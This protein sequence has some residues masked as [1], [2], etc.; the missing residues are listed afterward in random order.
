M[1]GKGLVTEV[2]TS[3]GVPP[4]QVEF[5]PAAESL[6]HRP[7]TWGDFAEFVDEVVL[8][9]LLRDNPAVVAAVLATRED[10]QRA[11]ELA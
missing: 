10:R 6:G 5:R 8:D 2:E 9:R 7:I 11:I 3:G 1:R 4:E